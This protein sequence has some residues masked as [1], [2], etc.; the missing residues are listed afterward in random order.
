MWNDED[1]NPYGTSFDGREPGELM[2]FMVYDL[3]KVEEEKADCVLLSGNQASSIDD[4]SNYLAFS[5]TRQEYQHDEESDS[6]EDYSNQHGK[7]SPK[8]Y[9]SR[10]LQILHENP[11]LPIQ[12]TDAGKSLESGGKYIVYTIRTGVCI[13][14]FR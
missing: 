10:I 5:T 11:D 12:I 6:D 13:Y 14:N 4:E 7:S 9:E 1:N 2:H 8:S 3:Q